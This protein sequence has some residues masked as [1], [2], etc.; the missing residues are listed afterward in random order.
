[1]EHQ[2]RPTTSLQRLANIAPLSGVLS[3]PKNLKPGAALLCFLHGRGEAQPMDAITAMT[4]HGPLNPRSALDAEGLA[5]QFIVVAPQLPVAGDHWHVFADVVANLV[6]EIEARHATDSARRYL[7]GFSFGGNGVF[8]LGHRQPA[9]WAALWAV[10]ATR[11][12][13]PDLKAPLWLSVGSSAR[14]VADTTSTRLGSVEL[15]ANATDAP[16]GATRIHIDQGE[17]HTETAERAYADARI[18]RWLLRQSLQG[19]SEKLGLGA[20]RPIQK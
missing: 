12:P 14:P 3:L 1:M 9:L 6:L 7:T 10:D 8:D 11:I 2:H 17:G 4:M 15:D 18:Y 20:A 13:E 5:R 16:L 19:S